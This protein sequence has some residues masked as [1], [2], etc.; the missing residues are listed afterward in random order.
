[1][2]KKDFNRFVEQAS[3]EKKSKNID[4]EKRRE[5][6]I[7]NL[8][9]F[10]KKINSFLNSF[11]EKGKISIEFQ[12]IELTEEHIGTYETKS[13][14]IF[15]GDHTIR[16]RPIGTTLIAAKGRVDM[17]GAYGKVKFVLVPESAD[18]PQIRVMINTEY[19]AETA[20]ETR[21]NGNETSDWVWKIATSPPAI[22]Y[23]PL[24][25]ESFMDAVMEVTNADSEDTDG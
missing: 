9:E 2:S 20:S 7:H 14:T 16:L 18:K 23:L 21:N 12:D 24:D 1:M 5:E 22:R 3:K 8:D 17:T 11:I 10:Y 25:E 19:Q 15:I 6:W 4:W 13:A